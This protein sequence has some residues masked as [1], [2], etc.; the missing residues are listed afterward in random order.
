MRSLNITQSGIRRLYLAYLWP[1]VAGM[2]VT[3][4]Y[5][6]VDTIFIGR[7]LGTKGLAALDLSL[8]LYNLFT[9]IGYLFGM[10]G[11]TAYA[12]SLGRRKDA[13][14]QSLF[15]GLVVS[16]LICV[17]G[18]L[19][20]NQIM[21]MLGASASTVHYLREYVGVLLYF[22]PCLI[23]VTLLSPFVSNDQAPQ[24]VMWGFVIGGLTNIFLDAWFIFA[25]KWGMWGAGL[26][27]GLSATV[28]VLIL[29]TR[30]FSP[31]ARLKVR[32]GPLRG[33][34]RV[35][36]NGFPSFV[37]EFSTGLVVLVFNTVLMKTVGD[38]GVAAHGIIAN[39]SIVCVSVFQGI[40]H[41]LQPLVSYNFGAKKWRRVA[42]VRNLGFFTAAFVGFVLWAMG[43]AF[44]KQIAAIF[45]RDEPQLMIF[46]V[47]AIRLYFWAFL[48]MGM[49]V[50][51]IAYF[52]SLEFSSH[53]V[54]IAMSRSVIFVVATLLCL[55]RSL[56]LDGVWLSIPVAEALALILGFYL[57]LKKP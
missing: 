49:N 40:G 31:H 53:A 30:F 36:L 9:A 27:T 15:W 33:A 20:L 1:S 5:V 11:A 18:L 14:W 45:M 22:S 28:N 8:P 48:P 4:F 12:A 46:A 42:R 32:I 47:K 43:Q 35:L 38:V 26:A 54:L 44:P 41:A 25:L 55:P 7:S 37:G 29:S 16:V 57:A 13:I 56:G 39:I 21:S 2:L 51:L 23:F 17:F 24:L 19:F 3:S 10:G 52:Q 34:W 50:V 6:L